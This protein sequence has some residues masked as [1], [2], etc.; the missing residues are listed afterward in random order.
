[1]NKNGVSRDKQN[2]FTVEDGWELIT[3]FGDG[4]R[5]LE[6]LRAGAMVFLV[7]SSSQKQLPKS[8]S[9]G[10]DYSR[11]TVTPTIR[12]R[13]MKHFR[14]VRL[15]SVKLKCLSPREAEVLELLALGCHYLEIGEKLNIGL[16]T[17]RTHVKGICSK[18]Q[19]RNR[20]E[21][22]ANYNNDRKG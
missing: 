17:V 11:S 12:L 2:E 4:E 1:M 16:E 19:V 5:I 7:K 8:I 22:V 18:M 13:T 14:L 9:I 6:A 20:I 15:T 21:A 3:I 10:D